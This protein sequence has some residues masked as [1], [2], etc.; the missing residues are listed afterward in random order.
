MAQG[1]SR[2]HS[3]QRHWT[4]LFILFIADINSYLPTGVNIK[5]YADDILAYLIG[6]YDTNLPQAIVEGIN[7]W[8]IENKMRLNSTKCK[9]L[10]F[11]SKNSITPPVISLNGSVLEEVTTY[12]Y[13][14]I[15]LNINLNWD[16]QWDRVQSITKSF[17]FLLRKLKKSGFRGP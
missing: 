17:P 3:K 10:P 9:I 16:S 5:K 13:L 1:S 14:G 4:I 2:S 12:K 7:K 8:C 15:N 6:K 11:S